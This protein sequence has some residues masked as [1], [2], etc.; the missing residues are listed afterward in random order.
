MANLPCPFGPNSLKTQPIS[1][2]YTGSTYA[3]FDATD[4]SSTPTPANSGPSGG[5]STIRIV[6]TG[7]KTAF[8]LWGVGTTTVPVAA[9]TACMPIIGGQTGYFTKAETDNQIAAITGGSDTTTLYITC[10]EGGIL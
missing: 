4:V 6:N 7:T 5:K 3:T 2:T 8:V 9:T 1:A 10:G